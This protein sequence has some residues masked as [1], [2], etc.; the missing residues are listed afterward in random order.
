MI[1][2]LATTQRSYLIKLKNTLS[3]MDL[4]IIFISGILSALSPCV[5]SILPLALLYIF[6]VSK[7]KYDSLLNSLFFILGFSFM[8]S[9]LGILFSAFGYFVNVTILKYL[10]SLLSSIFGLSLILNYNFKLF[11][12]ERG[13]VYNKIIKIANSKKLSFLS[14]FLF[15]LSFSLV[16]NIC[17]T[18]ILIS[19]LSYVATKKDLIFG[20]LSL[21]IYSIGFSLPIFI[22]SIIGGKGK[23]FL[24]KMNPKVVNIISGIILIFLSIYIVIT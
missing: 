24:E 13:K 3:N 22:F 21:F 18:P 6:G 7:D 14:S 12:E 20:F 23:E 4:I 1:K 5:L 2:P 8:F 15:G 9:L 11:S 17:S 19:I 10:A 16:A